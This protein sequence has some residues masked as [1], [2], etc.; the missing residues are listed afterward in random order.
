M[1][2]QFN[3]KAKDSSC[4]I[5]SIIGSDEHV[6]FME[7]YAYGSPVNVVRDRLMLDYRADAPIVRDFERFMGSCVG[8]DY[9]KVTSISGGDSVLVK[10]DN[11]K[12]ISTI[13]GNE[14]EMSES[15]ISSFIHDYVG[16]LNDSDLYM[17]VNGKKV[18]ANGQ[19]FVNL[20]HHAYMQIRRS[21]F[22]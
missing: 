21:H 3:S 12:V 5:T 1:I 22:N 13:S 7:D 20:Y 16:I 11:G 17:N 9:S 6:R 2:D 19:K 18:S 8:A 4:T 14:S 10:V 15:E